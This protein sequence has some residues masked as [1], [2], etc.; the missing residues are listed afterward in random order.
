MSM[1][2]EAREAS[3]AARRETRPD[4]LLIELDGHG[5]P[6]AVRRALRESV[7]VREVVVAGRACRALAD[8]GTAPQV[9]GALR[10][11][12]LDLAVVILQWMAVTPARGGF[13]V[14]APVVATAP[15][16]MPARRPGA[17]MLTRLIVVTTMPGLAGTT[18]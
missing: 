15:V 9:A 2:M 17:A 11:Q 18:R 1:V 14:P 3:P 10:A 4:L 8:P 7:C 5:C 16:R 13:S 6:D 12:G